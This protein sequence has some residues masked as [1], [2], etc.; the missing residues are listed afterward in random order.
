MDNIQTTAL[1]SVR[2]RTIDYLRRKARSIELQA[3]RAAPVAAPQLKSLAELMQVEA[4]ELERGGGGLAG[5]PS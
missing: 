5:C 4:E 2:R 3:A 1:P